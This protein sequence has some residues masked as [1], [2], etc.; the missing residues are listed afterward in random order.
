M[1]NK[2]QQTPMDKLTANYEKLIKGKELV[3]GGKEAFNKA[4][5][6]A[7]KPKQRGAK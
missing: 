6:K 5:K 7:T 3:Q 4:L 2:K 1:A